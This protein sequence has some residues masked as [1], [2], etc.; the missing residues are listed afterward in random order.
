ML[1]SELGIRGVCQ[2]PGDSRADIFDQTLGKKKPPI[3]MEETARHDKS[4]VGETTRRLETT[5]FFVIFFK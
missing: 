3:L 5:L 2:V 4:D 1:Q